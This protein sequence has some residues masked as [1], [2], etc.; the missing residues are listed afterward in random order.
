MTTIPY[1]STLARAGKHRIIAT[2]TGEPFT[3]LSFD[4]RGPHPLIGYFGDCQT[5]CAITDPATDLRLVA[6]DEPD[7]WAAEKA[8][9]AAGKRIQCRRAPGLDEWCDCIPSWTSEHEYRIAPDPVRWD[10][11][12]DVPGPLCWLKAGR[13]GHYLCTAV[14]EQGVSIR[15]DTARRF[16]GWGELATAWQHST[17]RKTW[18]PCVKPEANP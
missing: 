10:C 7:K 12:D 2:A 1:D 13:W 6:P 18:K 3:P 4:A 8:A 9:H 15:G 5:P 14:T 11:P 16:I 17:D